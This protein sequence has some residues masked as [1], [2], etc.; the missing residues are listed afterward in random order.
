MSRQFKVI[1][2]NATKNEPHTHKRITTQE[3]LKRF[4]EITAS[5]LHDAEDIWADLW[6]EF[7]GAVAEGVTISRNAEKGFFKPACGW[8]EFLEKM[9][10]LKHYL[11]YAYHFC[12]EQDPGKG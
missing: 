10:L 7:E 5:V 12:K 8:P 9:W 4:Q 1:S 6:N 2:N 3:K 11:D